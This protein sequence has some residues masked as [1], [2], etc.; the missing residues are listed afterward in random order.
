MLEHLSNF[1]Q[2][3][4]TFSCIRQYFVIFELNT[5][6]SGSL[7]ISF[8]ALFWPCQSVRSVCFV[9]DRLEQNIKSN[10]YYLTRLFYFVLFCFVFISPDIS[11]HHLPDWPGG[12]MKLGSCLF[13]LLCDAASFVLSGIGEV[14]NCSINFGSYCCYY[15]YCYC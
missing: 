2:Y 9:S 4:C 7:R 1:L 5:S 3:H 14:V 10:K 6:P 13:F 8:F 15:Y 12:H 11:D